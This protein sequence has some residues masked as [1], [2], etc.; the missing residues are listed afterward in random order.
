MKWIVCLLAVALFVLHQD[1]WNFNKAE[2]LFLNFPV[3][4]W[5]HAAFS[6]ACSV[7]MFLLVRFAWPKHLEKY[8]ALPPRPGASDDAH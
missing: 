5:Y 4:L 6:V 8:E 7:L 2:P 1:F 3:G